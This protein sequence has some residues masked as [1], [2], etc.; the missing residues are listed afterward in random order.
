MAS[1]FCSDSSRLVEYAHRAGQGLFAEDACEIDVLDWPPGASPYIEDLRGT[2]LSQGDWT[3]IRSAFYLRWK[4]C[5][6]FQKAA[7]TL[8]VFSAS[9][10][11]RER[12]GRLHVNPDWEV[13][14]V[15]PYSLYVIV[16]DEIWLQAESITNGVRQ[17]FGFM[18]RSELDRSSKVRSGERSEHDF[19]GLHNVAKHIIFLKEA[20]EA[21]LLMA[22]RLYQHHQEL[23]DGPPQGGSAK[24]TMQLV[25]Q[26]LSQKVTQF[27][28]WKLQM[29]SMNARMEN[30]IN[31][32]R[33]LL[34]EILCAE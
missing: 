15:D 28:V 19:V 9:P 22:Q 18:E 33:T 11:L 24:S 8:I 14:L 5:D 16:L 26:M 10:E 31:L 32:V 1:S 20:A 7:V 30:V 3:W 27:E 23:L 25:H 21:A 29:E 4:T 13:T 2:N 34:M 17:V 12:L 6:N